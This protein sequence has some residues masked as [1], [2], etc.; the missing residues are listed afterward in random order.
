MKFTKQFYI[1]AFIESLAITG[2]QRGIYL[3]GKY[4]YQFPTENI[5]WLTLCFGV[6]YV[7]ASFS[8]QKITD[9]IGEKKTLVAALFLQLP[10]IFSCLFCY[11]FTSYLIVLGMIGFLNGIKWPIVQSYISA[12]KSPG[13]TAK[14]VNIFNLCWSTGVPIGVMLAGE[15]SA[16][17]FLHQEGSL[18]Y[19]IPCAIIIISLFCALLAP[20]KPNH[21]NTDHPARPTA[22]TLKKLSNLLNAHRTSMF[23]CYA[24]MM[25]FVALLPGIFKNLGVSQ[26]YNSVY[27][28]SMDW[29]RLAVF[30]FLGAYTGWHGKSWPIYVSILLMPISFFVAISATTIQLV[31]LCEVIFGLTMGLSYVGS[32]YYAQLI[33][34]AAVDAGGKHEGLIGLSAAIG[35]GLCLIGSGFTSSLGSVFLGQLATLLPLFLLTGF[36]SVKFS[37]RAD[38]VPLP[39]NKAYES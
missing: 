18:V 6:F 20:S 25:V 28:S 27:T 37:R 30:I 3:L 29:V 21:L 5:V 10:L 14:A 12:G 23:G 19:L 2:L 8:A 24:A 11:S 1:I 35:P 7:I 32:L 13:N 22:A 4:K 33:K 26:E 17:M 36:I 34:N 38:S 9:R 16:I 39:T 15:L 31:I